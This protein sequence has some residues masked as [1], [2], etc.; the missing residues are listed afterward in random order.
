[1]PLAPPLTSVLGAP[2]RL[3]FL[4]GAGVWVAAS[5]AWALW[6]AAAAARAVPVAPWMPGVH[7]LVF[8]L[9]PM[10]LF[11]VGFLCTAGP[12]WL[13]VPPVPAREL[14]PAVLVVVLGWACVLAAAPAGPAGVSVG[15]A[16]CAAG[17]A[18]LCRRLWRLRADARARDAGIDLTHFDRASWACVALTLALAAGAGAAPGRADLLRG[19]ATTGLWWGVVGVFVTV[20]HRM[21]PFLG[22][23]PD[24]PDAPWLRRWPRARLDGLGVSAV[25]AGLAAWV[26]PGAGAP[27]ALE[28]AFGLHA[29]VVAAVSA[30]WFASWWRHPARQT[31]VFGLLHR[32]F[33]WW[34]LAWA[35]WAV[36]R[37]APLP[38]GAAVMLATAA[39]HALTLGYLGGTLLAMATRVSATQAG[40]ATAIDRT[41]R[42]LDAML[43]AAVLARVAAAL[44]PAAAQGPMLAAA[45]LWAAIAVAWL[46]RHRRD[47]T[48]APLRG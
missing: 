46:H 23:T 37:L 11:I 5:V 12:R 34:V 31:P 32:A 45:A 40:R 29:L 9:G 15:L 17:W 13:R 39:L 44:W 10:P 18:G 36:A 1:M 28:W 21:L 6:L 20:S 33:G 22:P 27:A 19:I 25:V 42:T 8:G 48:R 47:F 26:P 14:A 43:Q 16:A 38:P 41:A 30:R 3:C 24:Q 35:A 4:A 7:A 2:H